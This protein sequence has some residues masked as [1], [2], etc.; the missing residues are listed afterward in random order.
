MNL[1][2]NKS[3]VIFDFDGT[4]YDK[5]NFALHLVLPHLFQSLKMKAERN[6]RK[7]LKGKY[8]GSSQ[9][10]YNAFFAEISRQTKISPQKIGNWYSRK[11]LPLM[12]KILQKK[13]NAFPQTEEIF[14]NLRKAGIKTIVYSDYSCVAERMTAIGL[15]PS[16]A[17]ILLSAED[18]GGLKPAAEPLLQLAQKINVEPKNILVVGDR[19]DTDGE[20]ARRTGMSFAHISQQT[21]L[22]TY[23]SQYLP[24]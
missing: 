17:D 9:E 20:L 6:A 5:K 1:M 8:F 4:L 10:F 24:S 3:A 12:T 15:D 14:R 13:Y 18:A 22:A 7:S 16:L 11:Y 23:F 19:D 21:P 2:E